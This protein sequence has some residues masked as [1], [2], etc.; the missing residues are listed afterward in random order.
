LADVKSL[1]YLVAMVALQEARAKGFDDALLVGGR[2][3]V[4]EATRSNFF[5]FFGNTLV[6]ANEGILPGV[7][8]G[9][10]LTL[11][12]RF[13][14]TKEKKFFLKDLKKAEEAFITSSDKEILPVV[15]V[16][17]TVIGDGKVGWR[18]RQLMREFKLLTGR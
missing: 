3:E 2:G 5:A 6:T 16:G 12:R 10:V 8:R 17:K 13:F 14:R 1:D 7:T 15:R 11:A 4:F 18:T 9:L